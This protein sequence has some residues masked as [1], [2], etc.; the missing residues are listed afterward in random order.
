MTVAQLS[1]DDAVAAKKKRWLKR[2]RHRKAA[3]AAENDVGG[4]AVASDAALGVPTEE[5]QERRLMGALRAATNRAFTIHKRR[6]R[7]VTPTTFHIAPI[8]I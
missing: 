5:R 4:A 8:D 2:D 3:A 6:A 7:R 1:V